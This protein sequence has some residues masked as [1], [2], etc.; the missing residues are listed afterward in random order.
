MKLQYTN[1]ARRAQQGFEAGT[2]RTLSENPTP[3]P[4]SPLKKFQV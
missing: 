1:A 2:S 3:K 4:T